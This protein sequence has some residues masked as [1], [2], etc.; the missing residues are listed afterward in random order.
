[1]AA[2]RRAW[3][4]WAETAVDHRCT[5]L[6]RVAERMRARRFELAAGI[7]IEAGKPWREADGDVAEAIDYCE[8][9]AAEMTRLHR[10][11]HRRDV[12]GEQNRMVHEPRGVAAIIAPW[13][14]PLAILTGM[15]AAALVAGNTVVVKPS[16]QTPVIAAKL[17]DMLIEAGVPPGVANFVPGRGEDVGAHLVAHP[18]IDLIAFTG[19]RPVGLG[20]IETAARTSPQQRSVKRVIAEMGGKNAVIVDTDADLDD[21]VRGVIAAAFGYAGQKCSACS[22]VIVLRPVHDVFIRRLVDSARSLRVGPAD[23]PA[24]VVGPLIDAEARDNVLRYIEIGKSEAVV[25]CEVEHADPSGYYV[26]PVI[27]DRVLPQHVIA[28]EEIFGPVLSVM[29]ADTFE[30]AIGIANDTGYAL[31][32]GVYTRRP[33]H[34]ECARRAFRVGNLYIGRPITGALVDRQ[35]FGGRGLS[36]IGAKAG[37]PDYLPQFCESKTISENT[38]RHGFA[39]LE[40]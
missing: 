40:T 5:L 20:I 38:V 1:V 8:Y 10:H 26:G 9:Y 4:A 31:T 17:F 21:A 27:F 19:S 3:P 12:L 14:F 15:T 7:V 37:G 34:I 24:T 33:S 30:T 29:V 23:D 13:N 2:A 6:R 28:Q 22:R 16:E 39:P 11:P 18:Q 32:G 36:G 25:A 35:P